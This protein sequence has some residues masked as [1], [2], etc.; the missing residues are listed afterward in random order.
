M[1]AHRQ[2]LVVQSDVVVHEST[3][4]ELGDASI[5]LGLLNTFLGWRAN[6]AVESLVDQLWPLKGCVQ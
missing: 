6:R 3:S 1:Q 2:N 4:L 5:I